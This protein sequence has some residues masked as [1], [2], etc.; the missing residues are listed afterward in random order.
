MAALWFKFPDELLFYKKFSED[1]KK[2]LNDIFSATEKNSPWLK[3]LT[4][5]KL[6]MPTYEGDIIHWHCNAPYFNWTILA[7]IV[8]GG[9]MYPKKSDD[10]DGYSFAMSYKIKDVISLLKSQWKVS[11]FLSKSKNND[12]DKLVNSIA[13]G[14]CLQALILRLGSDYKHMPEWLASPDDAPRKH[15]GVILQIQSVQMDRTN[16]SNVWDNLFDKSVSNITAKTGLPEFFW[17]DNIPPN[18]K[19]VGSDTPTKTDSWKGTPVSTGSLTGLAIKVGRDFD[20]ETINDL[21]EKYNAPIIL[22]FKDARPD[23]VE[24]FPHADALLFAT[25]GTLCHACTV[26]RD[27]NI[28]TITALGNSFL[29]QLFHSDEHIW[30]TINGKKGTIERA[31]RT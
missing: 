30:L 9:T 23:T 12:A 24:L 21:K 29:K 10:G 18:L 11:S 15:K 5:L 3:A 4:L 17:D 2:K 16:I 19:I 25:G 28:P 7:D 26:A 1:N 8:S 27:M 6:E 14:L 22:V 13:L 20:S 31:T